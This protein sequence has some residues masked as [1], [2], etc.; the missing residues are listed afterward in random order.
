M[1]NRKPF[2]IL[3][4]LRHES[5]TFTLNALGLWRLEYHG[6]NPQMAANDNDAEERPIEQESYRYELTAEEL[7]AAHAA[8]EYSAAL[9]DETRKPQV[10]RIKKPMPLPPDVDAEDETARHIDALKMRNWL[11]SDAEILDMA[12][13]P[14]T[15]EDIGRHIGV[16]S[17]DKTAYRAGRQEVKDVAKAFWD[18]A[19]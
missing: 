2:P 17:S 18:E 13:G 14:H 9:H 12:I 1:T 8:G 5:D 11:G 16:N 4:A 6:V 19:A 3:S 7:I 10:R 15:Y